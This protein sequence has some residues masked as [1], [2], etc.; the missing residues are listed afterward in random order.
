MR[1][2]AK[3]VGI[4]TLVAVLGVAA[5]G[6]AA[7]AQDTSSS[8]TPFDFA[9]KFKE[10]LASAL[11][12][13]VDEYDAAVEKAQGQV[14]DE[15]VA[16]GWLTQDQA[17]LLQWRMDQA[18]GPGM[19]GMGRG[20]GELGHGMM[21]GEDNLLS[22][23]ADQLG[24]K[25]TDLL[26]ELQGGKSIADVAGEKGVDT[27]VIIDAYLAQIKTNPEAGRLPVAADGAAGNRPVEQHGDRG[28]SRRWAAWGAD[29][30]LPWPWRTLVANVPLKWGANVRKGDRRSPLQE[31]QL[32]V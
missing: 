4:A 9:T 22:I 18:P 28:L 16:E 6:V 25:L 2:I 7:Y 12:I 32:V 26:T 5:V 20:F 30:W 31:P 27:Q 19:P 23:A 14:V 1:K 8:N 10:A 21:G 11:G 24:M 17:D 15:A 3:I 13:S 29:G